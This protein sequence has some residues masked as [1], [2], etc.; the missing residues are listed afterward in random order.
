MTE[1]QKN[2]VIMS[3][4]ELI[5]Y[6]ESRGGYLHEPHFLTTAK[7]LKNELEFEGMDEMKVQ[8]IKEHRNGIRNRA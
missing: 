2:R 1:G 7:D 4:R 5:E 6:I 3:L 8:S